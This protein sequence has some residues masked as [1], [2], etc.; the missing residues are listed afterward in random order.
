MREPEVGEKKRKETI[1]QKVNGTGKCVHQHAR[2]R[3]SLFVKPRREAEQK[4]IDTHAG[5]K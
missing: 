4:K 5:W 2:V 3:E 1:K